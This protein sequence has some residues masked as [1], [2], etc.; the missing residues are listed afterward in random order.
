MSKSRNFSKEF[1]SIT[2]W[3]PSVK[4]GP[5]FINVFLD[6]EKATVTF[7]SYRKSV[8]NLHVTHVWCNNTWPAC[9]PKTLYVIF[10]GF[11]ACLYPEC[12]LVCN[13]YQRTNCTLVLVH[14][15]WI[16]CKPILLLPQQGWGLVEEVLPIVLKQ[17]YLALRL[18]VAEYHLNIPF[19]E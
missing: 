18:S 17:G 9:C 7:F 5:V 19:Y 12:R 16:I 1:R 2:D 4:V 14:L 6:V 11:C 15:V 8:L 10:N 13:L 3:L